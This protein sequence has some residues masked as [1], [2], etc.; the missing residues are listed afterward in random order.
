MTLLLTHPAS[1]DHLTPPGHPERPDR[2]RS[3]GEV[4]AEERF[5]PLVRMVPG[6]RKRSIRQRKIYTK[7]IEPRS[8]ESW[9]I[10][11]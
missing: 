11:S 8:S 3:V 6:S 1:L 2:L 4:L 7:S 10:H 5:K 9:G